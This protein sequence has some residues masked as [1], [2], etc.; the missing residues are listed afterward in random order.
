MS[1]PTFWRV[2][3]DFVRVVGPDAGV[4]LQGQLSQDVDAIA[5]GE[6]A[7][8]FL[9]Q[10]QGKVDAYLR[11]TR[12]A[13][14]ELVLDVDRGWG[15]AVIARLNRFKLRTKAD[16][17]PLEGWACIATTDDRGALV[18]R[19]GPALAGEGV[20]G[21][22]TGYES[23]RIRA[24]QPRM[25]SEIDETTIPASLGVVEQA[26]S[27]TKGCYTGQEL[28]ARIDSRG[29]HTPTKLVGYRGD[30]HP[31]DPVLVDGTEVGRITSVGD[32]VALAFVRRDVTVPSGPLEALP[33]A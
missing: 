10:P 12:V 32:G 5:P 23:A 16:V 30:A 13:D 29:G 15:D 4:F 18:E 25:G 27:F 22:A 19:V 3:R 6:S 11:V 26:V 9:L 31:G 24:G 17:E 21:D 7:R 1:E 8:S 2:P 14:D 28:V 33:M 20:E